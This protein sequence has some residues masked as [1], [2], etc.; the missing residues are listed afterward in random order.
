MM[1]AGFV[2]LA[3]LLSSIANDRKVL[4]VAVVL[5]AFAY[6]RCISLDIEVRREELRETWLPLFVSTGCYLLAAATLTEVALELID[7]WS[8]GD[9]GFAVM[10]F[11]RIVILPS[12]SIGFAAAILMT[13][14]KLSSGTMLLMFHALMVLFIMLPMLVY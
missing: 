6:A 11:L 10:F 8:S 2:I 7:Q 14:M 4:L 3:V 9:A 13:R 5:S 1:G 12:S